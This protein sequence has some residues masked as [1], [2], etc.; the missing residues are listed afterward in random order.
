MKCTA[1]LS[2]GKRK[3]QPCG[4][5]VKIGEF[6]GIHNRNRKISIP[7]YRRFCPSFFAMDKEQKAVPLRT[8]SPSEVRNIRVD[9]KDNDKENRMQV[10][11]CL[12]I[13]VQNKTK[14]KYQRKIIS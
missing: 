1:I 2:T 9:K 3:E 11:K 13:N 4:R 10:L 6:C 12:G 8:I 7:K 14:R 5:N